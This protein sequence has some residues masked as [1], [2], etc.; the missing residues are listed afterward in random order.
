MLSNPA[1]RRALRYSDVL[2]FAA[3]AS[4]EVD[5]PTDAVQYL[6]MVRSRV[7]LAAVVTT[8]KDSLRAAIY[9]ERRVE[10]ALEGD[11]FWDVVRQGNGA[12]AFGARGFKAGTNE[13]FAIPQAAI[14]AC[15]KLTQNSGY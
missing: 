12:K 6:N 10:L 7:G 8:D 2:L 3:E 13:V 15:N 14:D 9:H 5:N 1:N 4:N 11:R